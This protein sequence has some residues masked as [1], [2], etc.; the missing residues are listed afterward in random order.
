MARKLEEKIRIP[1]YHLDVLYW[2]PGWVKTERDKWRSIQEDLCSKDEWILDGNYGATLD[3]RIKTCD[4]IIF[5]DINKFICL[6]KAVWRSMKS[7]GKTRSD[8]AAGCKER[9]D[10]EFAKWILEYPTKNKPEIL[11]RL[12]CL[13]PEKNIIILRSAKEVAAFLNAS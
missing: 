6:A 10:I 7:H 12:Q 5:L 8:M 3:I 11:S 4:T 13:T 9:F 1:A 2:Q